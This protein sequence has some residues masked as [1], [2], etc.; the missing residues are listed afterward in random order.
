M[1]VDFV[2]RLEEQ[3]REA[4]AVPPAVRRRRRLAAAARPAAT[5]G[6]TA[7]L[8]AGAVGA[9]AVAA[10][11]DPGAGGTAAGE[12]PLPTALTER[13]PV[14]RPAPSLVPIPPP[15]TTEEPPPAR[16][17][18]HSAGPPPARTAPQPAFPPPARTTPAPDSTTPAGPPSARP[19]A[20]VPATPAPAPWPTTPASPAQ[21]VPAP[22]TQD[23]VPAQRPSVRVLNGTTTPGLAQR[24]ARVVA[25]LG[26]RGQPA[27]NAAT[28][29]AAR[30]TLYATEGNLTAAR[31]LAATLGVPGAIARLTPQVAALSPRAGIVMI[32]GRTP[33]PPRGV[34]TMQLTGPGGARGV[35][36]FVLRGDRQVALSLRHGALPSRR[37]L[38]AWI[39]TGSGWQRI[40]AFPASASTAH[41][42]VLAPVG[43][44]LPEALLLTAERS[45]TAPTRPGQTVL[46]SKG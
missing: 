24:V 6:A 11:D 46:T 5:L 35:A 12:G 7:A 9:V 21:P 42:A 26:Y 30:T 8:A 31:A 36:T 41:V 1:P 38:T 4:A 43:G 34:R 39:A 44:K 23:L 40:G 18:P 33:A 3:L 15:A 27:G 17:T 32:L 14:P 16:T 22:P 20:P 25:G 37:R 45:G 19:P 29:D 13:P 10:G 28:S 2:D